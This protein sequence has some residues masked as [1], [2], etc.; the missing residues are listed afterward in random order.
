MWRPYYD[1]ARPA[2]KVINVVTDLLFIFPFSITGM[3]LCRR[4][5]LF[6]LFY[7]LVGYYIVIHMVLASLI[8]HR[9]PLMPF[10][11]IF[12]A[13]ALEKIVEKRRLRVKM[14]QSS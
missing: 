12:A 11:I 14:G 7:L 1:T 5:K 6:A 4:R 13:C 8:R 3:I 9:L 10:L 2:N